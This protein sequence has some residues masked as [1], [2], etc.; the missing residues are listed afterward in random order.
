MVN[1]RLMEENYLAKKEQNKNKQK[2]PE[3]SFI[4]LFF[5]VKINNIPEKVAYDLYIDIHMVLALY[6]GKY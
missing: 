6:H 4:S 5:N 3:N 1:D 2:N